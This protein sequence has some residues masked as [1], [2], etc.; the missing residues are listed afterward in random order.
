MKNDRDQHHCLLHQQ[1]FSAEDADEDIEEFDEN[2][3]IPSSQPTQ[4]QP[5][6]ASNLLGS[7]ATNNTL[8]NH[9]GGNN[10]L[11]NTQ[12]SSSFPLSQFRPASS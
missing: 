4:H 10:S 7:N 12:Q 1:I 3:Y 8:N 9:I 5:N 11:Q 6:I 2:D